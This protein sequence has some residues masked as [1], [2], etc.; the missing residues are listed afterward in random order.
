MSKTVSGLTRR[1]ALAAAAALGL[2]RVL[3][4]AAAADVVDIDA[5]KAEGQVS[6]YTSAPIGAAQ[7]VAAAFEQRY[8]IKVELFR[9]GG[10]EVLRRFMMERAAGHAAA[11]VLV[12]SDPAAA[13]DL[14]AKGMFVPFRPAGFDQ[15]PATLNDPEGNYVAQRVS[16]IAIYGRTDLIAAADMPKTWD[17]L[18]LPKFKGKLVLTDPSFTSLQV[19]VVAMMSKAR[20]WDYYER[21]NKNDVLIV[22]GNEQAVNLVK[23]GERPIAAGADSQYANEARLAGHPI[24]TFFPTDGT[25]A[26][27]AVTAVVKG[28]PHPNAARLL[29]EYQLSLEA[30]RL[31]PPA[32]IY[33]ARLDVEPPAG[34]PTIGTVKV[35]PMDFAYIQRATPAVKK[36]FQEIFS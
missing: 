27:P 32:G 14:A 12:T 36:K 28:A 18:L 7:K 31:W 15:I 9:S 2:P 35:I 30:E 4:A 11:D 6:L 3:R 22:P 17:D 24:Q 26:I 34:S 13:I 33:A 10:S 19:G 8:G 5:A 21:L 16:L 23:T 1:S 20:G 25:F 29:A